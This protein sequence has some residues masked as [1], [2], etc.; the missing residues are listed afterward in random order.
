MII[1]FTLIFHF[2]HS[3]PPESVTKKDEGTPGAPLTAREGIRTV[4]YINYV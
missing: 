3:S 4:N 1:A 2:C